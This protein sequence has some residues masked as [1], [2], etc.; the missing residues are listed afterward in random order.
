MTQTP[1]APAASPAPTIPAPRPVAR[2][3]TAAAALTGLL[4]LGAAPG[5]ATD[6]SEV[7]AEEYYG[8][9][10]FQNALEHP[11]VAEQKSE[12][13][14]IA[15]VARDI[16]WNRRKLAAAIEKVRGLD[17]DPTELAKAALMSAFEASRVKGRV[18]EV[19]FNDSE[20]KHVVCYVR[21]RGSKG[22]EAVKEAST[23]A[24]L[25]AKHAPFVST[26]SLAAI[27]PKSA[28]DTKTSVWEGKI[29]RTAMERISPDRIDR[30]AERLY[31]RMFEDVKSRPF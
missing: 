6:V 23:I 17:G 8:A 5:A 31:A 3:F 12:R 30:Y 15:L 13:R 27:H 2:A 11:K 19:L 9:A 26:L 25:T 18:L 1:P 7:T 21:W 4:S 28:E 20:P 29:A 14:R 24:H 22:K 16:G 10:Y